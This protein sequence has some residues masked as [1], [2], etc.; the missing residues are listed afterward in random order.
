MESPEFS[1]IADAAGRE[2]RAGQN[3]GFVP[4]YSSFARSCAFL[5]V[6]G[7]GVAGARAADDGQDSLIHGLGQ[8]FGLLKTEKPKIDYRERAKLVLPPKKVLPPPVDS[9]HRNVAWPQDVEIVRDKKAQLLEDGEPSARQLA[10]R[11]FQFF[12]PGQDV[13]VTTSGFED[14]GSACR[15][16]NPTTGECPAP[17][18][19]SIEWN[20]MTW[21][22][23]QKKPPSVLGPEPERQSLEEPPKGYRAPAEGVGAKIDN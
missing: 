1:L 2:A 17:P 3:R 21:V 15:H 16:P 9:A 18:K 11:S 7:L 23:L 12:T 20:P 22:G 6:L 19:P 13:K 8:S 5:A 10:D 14:T 4:M